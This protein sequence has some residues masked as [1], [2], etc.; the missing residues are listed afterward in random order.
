MSECIEV[1]NPY[2]DEV[3]GT[4]P[5]ATDAEIQEAVKRSANAVEED[6]WTPYDRWELLQAV[7]RRIRGDQ[8]AFARL[9]CRETGKPIRDSRVEVERTCATLA[10]SGE[11]A[12]RLDGVIHSCGVTPARIQKHAHV[13][14]FP[15]GVVAA[16]TPFNFPMNIPSHKIGPA[17]AGGN[18]VI[19]KPSPRAPLTTQKLVEIFT[20]CGAGDRVQI[21]HGE[22]KVVETLCRSDVNLVTFTGSTHVGNQIA[23]WAA[24]RKICMELGGND[25]IIVMDD[26]DLP[27]AV[28]T[29]VAHRF[30]S[31]GQRCTSCKRVLAQEGIYDKL[32][33]LLLGKIRSLVVGDP[34]Q[35]ATDVGPLIC[36]RTAEEI[37]RRLDQAVAEGANVLCGG[38]REGKTIFPTLVENV[39]PRAALLCEETFGPV[40]PLIRF[41]TLNE[42]VTIVNA[43][44]Y[45]LQS[46]IF[47][48]RQDVIQSAF[49][50]LQ[51][52]A[53]IVNGGTGFR[54]EP[55]PFGGVKASGFGREGVRYA[56]DEF[57][58]LKTLVC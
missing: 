7:M 33:T 36:L 1:L 25:P 26:A 27:A 31:S 56:V 42:A 37:L 20:E 6:H 22:A 44:T 19:V 35:E 48:N 3:I 28:D 43:Q 52:G 30:G 17:L 23:E 4:V 38:T 15:V 10:W 13:M 9:I 5:V 45:G 57:T 40:L 11:E 55:I 39:P 49:R 24:G 50:K 32:K 58:I 34:A 29:I 51:V 54:I 47:T 2:N 8:E 41:S 21:L 18:A 12:L 46:A 16:I 53:L 14:R